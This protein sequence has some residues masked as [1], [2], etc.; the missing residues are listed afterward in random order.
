RAGTAAV[1][2]LALSRAGQ[3][4]GQRGA[5]DRLVEAEGDVGGDILT[6]RRTGRARTGAGAAATT[7]EITEQVAEPAGTRRRA[8]DVG[9]VE[10]RAAA[11][12]S[13]TAVATAETTAA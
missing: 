3:L 1:T 10:R 8:E 13:A 7:E 2:R 5:V 11:G 9:H 6:A 12:E 4:Q